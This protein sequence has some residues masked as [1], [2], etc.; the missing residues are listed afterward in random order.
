MKPQ[1][2]ACAHENWVAAEPIILRV[3]ERATQ[4]RQRKSPVSKSN[5]FVTVAASVRDS[6]NT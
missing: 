3:E 4:N 6:H 2:R 5:I 1:K